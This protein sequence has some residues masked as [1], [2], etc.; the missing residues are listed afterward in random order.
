MDGKEL[1]SEIDKAKGGFINI[2]KEF[3]G[4]LPYKVVVWPYS[5][6]NGFVERFEH[7]FPQN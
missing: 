4:E 3:Y 6:K 5:K 7:I 2:K 1:L